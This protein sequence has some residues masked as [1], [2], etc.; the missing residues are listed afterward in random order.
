[1][2]FAFCLKQ[3]FVAMRFFVNRSLYFQEKK[4]NIFQL[5]KPMI[6]QTCSSYWLNLKQL[7]KFNDNRNFFNPLLT[8]ETRFF[9]R[10]FR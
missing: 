7:N 4:T 10:I 6:S 8:K 5:T 2:F 1:M 3:V 9:L